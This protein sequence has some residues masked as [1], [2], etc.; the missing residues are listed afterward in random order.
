[1]RTLNSVLENGNVCRKAAVAFSDNYNW[2]VTQGLLMA[3]Y[4]LAVE[5]FNEKECI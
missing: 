5:K 1:V 3:G 2:N 4:I